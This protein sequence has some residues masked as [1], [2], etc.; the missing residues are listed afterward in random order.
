M[1]SLARWFSICSLAVA[2]LIALAS[3]VTSAK[4]DVQLWVRGKPF[5]IG[6]EWC[7]NAFGHHSNPRIE[8]RIADVHIPLWRIDQP[9]DCSLCRAGLTE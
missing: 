7:L 5:G 8:I 4:V 2:L 6:R 9:C 1:Q 3:F